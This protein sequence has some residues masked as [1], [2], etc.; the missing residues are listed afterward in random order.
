MRVL[1]AGASGAVGVP[2]VRLL[3]AGGH[4]VSGLV[5]SPAAAER[6]R[7]L[8]AAAVD[9]DVLDRDRLLRAVYGSTYDAVVHQLTAL[10][11]V[12]LRVG[13]MAA[14]NELRTRGTAHLLDVAHAVGARRFLTQS[15]VFGYGF[16]DHGPQPLT[17][18]NPFG[19]TRGDRFDP[20]VAALASAEQ[21]VFDDPQVAGVAL[22]YGLFYGRDLAVVER[23]LRRRSAPVTSSAATLALVHHDDA[24]AATVAALDRGQDD[25]AYNIVDDTP[26]SWRGYLTAV[27]EATRAPRPWMVPGPVLRAL[28]PYT[29]RLAT[30]VSMVVSNARAQQELGWRPRYPSCADGLRATVAGEVIA[31]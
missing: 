27:A 18:T 25:T 17:E 8:G 1:V 12:P 10:K 26:I 4:R 13:D 7:Q 14:T 24:A 2:L 6:L 22:R 3:V 23:L 19:V 20:V 16:R 11:K 31:P 28:A 5:R 15:I 9:A 30:E 29:G 21:Q